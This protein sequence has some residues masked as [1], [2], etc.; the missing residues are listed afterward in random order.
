MADNSKTEEQKPAEAKPLTQAELQAQLEAAKA[1]LA[2][3]EKSEIDL[4]GQLADVRKKLAQLQTISNARGSSAGEVIDGIQTFKSTVARVKHQNE[5]LAE[6][7]PASKPDKQP[8]PVTLKS[9]IVQDAAGVN[10]P[11]RV[12]D[13]IDESEAKRVVYDRLKFHP[14]EIKLRAVKPEVAAK[15]AAAKEAAAK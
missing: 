2:S 7:Y 5:K 6:L 1:E 15:Q 10:A 13:C 14:R 8:R 12:D 4:E 3:R 11:I 9:F